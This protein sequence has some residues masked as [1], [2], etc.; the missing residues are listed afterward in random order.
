MIVLTIVGILA[1]IALPMYQGSLVRAREA[2]LK[3]NLYNMRDAIDKHYADRGQY[4]ASLSELVSAKYMR[5]VPVDPLTNSIDTWVE[6]PADDGPGVYDV[7][8]GSSGTGANGTAYN[9]W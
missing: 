5:S 7:R 6:V 9:E 8:S 1:G 3:E 2:A 4:P